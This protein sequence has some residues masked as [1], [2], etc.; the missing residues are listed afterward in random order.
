[1]LFRSGKTQVQ[2]DGGALGGFQTAASITGQT[3]APQAVGIRAISSGDIQTTNWVAGNS[4]GSLASAFN[5]VTG[6]FTVPKNGYYDLNTFISLTIDVAPFNNIT[7]VANPNGF[8]GNGVPPTNTYN[9]AA[10]PQ[11]L[12]FNDYFG[13]FVIGITN[14]KA[15]GLAADIIYCANS[16]MLYYDISQIVISAT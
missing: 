12:D 11:T 6:I 10:P 3:F 2:V 8:V 4:Y 14:F 7:S 1:M 9:I 13:R 15:I 16:E 5:P